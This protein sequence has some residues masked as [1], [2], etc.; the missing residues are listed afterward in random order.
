[1]AAKITSAMFGHPHFL[2]WA[3]EANKHDCGAAPV[4]PVYCCHVLLWRQVPKR[5]RLHSGD[6]QLWQR[7]RETFAKFLYGIRG[8]AKEIDGHAFLGAAYAQRPHQVRSTYALLRREAQS[9]QH[10]CYRSAVGRCQVRP[11]DDLAKLRVACCTDDDMHVAEGGVAGF[12][13]QT[14]TD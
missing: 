5:G 12:T 9:P 14:P 3:S 13:C 10:P 11:V 4:N 2:L 6:D 7:R 8:A 1:M